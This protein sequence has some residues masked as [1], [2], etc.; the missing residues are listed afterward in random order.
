MAQVSLQQLIEIAR[1]ENGLISFPTDTVPALA[2]KPDHSAAIFQ[3][4]RRSP[5]KPL[6]LMAADWETLLPYVK[7]TEAER[8]AWQQI[9]NRHWPGALT[10]V[11]PSSDRVPP[12]VHR[13]NPTTV[14][15][16]IPNH[17]VAQVILRETGVL[18]T[19]SANV[20][21]EPPLRTLMAIA[22]TFPQVA[23]LEAEAIV[24]YAATLGAAAE[25]GSGL[26]ST[27]AK[28][29]PEGWSILRQGSVKL[30]DAPSA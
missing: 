10:L 21:G 18:A 26:P 20:S 9:A 2:A 27:V 17:P 14:G 4:K 15:V 6:I 19:T 23:V 5:T 7:G 30:E 22:Q 24:P 13:L 29:T 3:A 8:Q 25:Q 12:D 11:L 1:G 28:W 16:R